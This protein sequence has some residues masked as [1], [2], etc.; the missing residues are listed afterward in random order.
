MYLH[1]YY[2]VLWVVIDAWTLVTCTLEIVCN[3]L[4]V[5]EMCNY[6]KPHTSY[7]QITF[8]GTLIILTI[9]LCWPP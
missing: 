3:I 7:T 2:E 9:F 8:Q 4:A 6:N 1:A 5:P